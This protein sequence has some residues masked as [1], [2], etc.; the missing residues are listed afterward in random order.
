MA[1]RGA[2]DAQASHVQ[3]GKLSNAT[4][5]AVEL[6]A[7]A[8]QAG[9]GCDL[10]AR[11]HRAPR[12]FAAA[13][14]RC[15]PRRAGGAGMID[16]IYGFGQG[17]IAAGW[18]TGAAWPLIWT[19]IKIVAVV[20]APDGRGGLPDAVGA[21]GH[22]LHPDPPRPQ[23]H[24]PA[25]PAAAD[26]RCAEAADQGNH[27]A[28]G[29][30]QGPVPAG[31]DHDH[32]AG[33]GRL[34]RDSVRSRHRAGQHQRRPA[35]PDGD[36]LA[37]GLRRDHRRLGVQL[38]VRLPGRAARFGA[39]GELRNRHGLLPGGGADGLRQPEPDRHRHGPGQG[40]VRRTRA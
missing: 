11:Q 24:R 23:P 10:P 27:P 39:D 3:G 29:G 8:R 7:S 1:A 4:S 32:H 9:H 12:A 20:A 38:E 34:G 17:L 5:A 19:L 30:Q 36:H 22:R 40:H 21:Q 37:G 18:W 15:A 13:D 35:V 31:P 16:Q 25:R 26:R 28:D 33:A 14:G 2:Q 6:S